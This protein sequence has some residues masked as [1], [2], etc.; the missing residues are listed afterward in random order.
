MDDLDSERYDF[1]SA[2]RF[3]NLVTNIEAAATLAALYRLGYTK[4]FNDAKLL[5]AFCEDYI[6]EPYHP[7]ADTRPTAERL[8]WAKSSA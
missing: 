7:M 1:W 4:G 5:E 6:P 3:L 8:N 2:L